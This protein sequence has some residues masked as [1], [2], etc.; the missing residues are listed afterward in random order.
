MYLWAFRNRVKW[1]EW[2]CTIVAAALFA[3]PARDRDTIDF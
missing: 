3:A 1:Y 2:F